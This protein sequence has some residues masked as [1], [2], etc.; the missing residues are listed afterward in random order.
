M[1]RND[2]FMDSDNDMSC[3][4]IKMF[5]QIDLQIKKKKKKEYQ[6]GKMALP[7]TSPLQHQNL[8]DNRINIIIHQF[9]TT[10]YFKIMR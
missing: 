5:V 8:D 6:K 7:Q 2:S 10:F 4:N 1:A 3:K 9:G